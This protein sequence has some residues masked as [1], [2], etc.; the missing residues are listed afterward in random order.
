MSMKR[1]LTAITFLVGVI[2][3]GA[4]SGAQSDSKLEAKTLFEDGVALFQAQNYFAAAEKF[5]RSAALYPT[6]MGLFNLA[7]CRLVLHQY[8]DALQ[9]IT[10]L[11][12]RF[13]DKLD[14]GWRREVDNFKSR[15]FDQIGELIVI[16]NEHH[17]V[18]FLDG[19]PVG[20]TP[21][22]ERYILK[23]GPHEVKVNKPGFFPIA[24]TVEIV[25]R[26]A[27]EEHFDLES[28]PVKQDPEAFIASETVDRDAEAFVALEPSTDTQAQL[29][30]VRAVT[31][32]DRF[33]PPLL[34]T[35]VGLTAAAAVVSVVFLGL[36]RSEATDFDSTQADHERVVEVLNKNPNYVN[37]QTQED[38]LYNKMSDTK[39]RAEHYGSLGVGFAIGA[40]VV[41][42]A[43]VAMLVFHFKKRKFHHK[44]ST[45]SVEPAPVGIALRF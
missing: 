27:V 23:K 42:A 26:E 24:R 31:P 33:K 44:E 18:V 15:L 37:L 1:Q 29:E 38:D 5:Q 14:M 28:E 19:R 2:V 45:A 36:A 22:S 35:G 13:G 17:A 12:G 10:E 4:A 43:T 34:W 20:E 16:V 41:G 8:D 11:E 25:P 40:G 7:N 9:T 30:L 39:N 32:G 3:H 21:L 6:K